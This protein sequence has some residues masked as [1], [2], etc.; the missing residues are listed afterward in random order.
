MVGL[1]RVSGVVGLERVSGVV[2]LER[3]SG[4]VGLERVSGVVG[5]EICVSKKKVAVGFGGTGFDT[6]TM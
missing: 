6:C 5:L 4:V 1:E 2:G 3:V